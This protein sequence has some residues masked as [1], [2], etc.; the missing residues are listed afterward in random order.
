MLTGIDYFVVIAYL[1]GILLLGYYFRIYVS[2]SDD[3]LLS[4]CEALVTKVHALGP[5]YQ[6]HF[7]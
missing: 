5:E 6:N 2:S 1:A 4:G 3:F 7:K